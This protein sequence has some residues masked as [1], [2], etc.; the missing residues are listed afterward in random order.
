[1]QKQAKNDDDEHADPPRVAHED[2]KQGVFGHF[3]FHRCFLRFFKNLLQRKIHHLPHDALGLGAIAAKSPHRRCALRGIKT[4]LPQLDDDVCWMS[5][6][7]INQN[8]HE[9]VGVF[10]GGVA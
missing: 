1:M 10:V 9:P 7:V 4:Q 5:H 2:G 6:C 8:G 3:E